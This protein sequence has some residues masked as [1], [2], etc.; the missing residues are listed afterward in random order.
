M[1]AA[2][3][4][5]ARRTPLE[6]SYRL[7]LR[8]YPAGYRARHGAEMLGMLMEI[9]GPRRLPPPRETWALLGG[10]LATRARRAVERPGAWW[11]DGLHLGVLL[12]ALA[13]LAYAALDHTRPGETAAIWVAVSA[14]LV[15]ALLRGMARTALPLALV[16]AFGVSRSMLF[17]TGALGWPGFDGPAY[18]NWISLAPYGAMA[19]GALVLAARPAREARARSWWWLA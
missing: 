2:A 11:A 4:P 1:S 18:H 17:G 9:S 15:L 5:G 12:L 13:N 3:V 14:A 8:A 6:R 16:V 7:L 19:A 10:G